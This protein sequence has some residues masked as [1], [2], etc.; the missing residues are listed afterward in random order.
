M[1]SHLILSAAITSLI[2]AG[3]GSSDDAAIPQTKKTSPNNGVD[4]NIA[5]KIAKTKAEREWIGQWK[6]SKKAINGI[7]IVINI[8]GGRKFTMDFVGN[9]SVV[10]TGS[11][12]LIFDGESDRQAMLKILN[13]TPADAQMSR[14]EIFTMMIDGNTGNLIPMQAGGEESVSVKMT[15]EK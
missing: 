13:A 11:G 10:E 12:K 3:C 1:K 8:T 14:Y 6:S 5:Q 9:N 2:L 4:P 15:K 7:Q